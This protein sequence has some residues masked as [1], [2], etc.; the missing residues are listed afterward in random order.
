MVPGSM[1]VVGIPEPSFLSSPLWVVGYLIPC[2][3]RSELP[4]AAGM[5]VETSVGFSAEWGDDIA[6]QP[7]MTKDRM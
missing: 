4:L 6:C 3:P 1:A 7:H 2:A 5:V